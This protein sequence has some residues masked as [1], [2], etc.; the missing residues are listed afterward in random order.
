[1]KQHILKFGYDRYAF[2]TAQQAAKAYELLSGAMLVEE[3][4]HSDEKGL[5]QEVE[6]KNDFELKRENFK[7][8]TDKQVEKAEINEKAWSEE[9]KLKY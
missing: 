7:F 9:N 3:L 4:I 8:A 2:K 5:W 6:S 1:M